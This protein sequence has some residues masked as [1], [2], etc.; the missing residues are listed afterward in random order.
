MGQRWFSVCRAISIQAQGGVEHECS[1]LGLQQHAPIRVDLLVMVQSQVVDVLPGCD[2]G[3]RWARLADAGE[4]R[5]KNKNTSR[6]R[7]LFPRKAV[8]Y[9]L[10]EEKRS[11]HWR[12]VSEI[13]SLGRLL[14][15]TPLWAWPSKRHISIFARIDVV[16]PFIQ[17]TS[18]CVPSSTRIAS[19][20]AYS[21][22]HHLN[23]RC[24]S[25]RGTSILDRLNALNIL[26]K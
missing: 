5:A 14:S 6:S 20:S 8:I 24:G 19:P 22:G 17:S 2:D 11:G 10:W 18:R 26:Q 7:L 1:Y 9:P 3:P 16:R 12:S 15:T 23:G 13:A 4:L 25:G 21:P